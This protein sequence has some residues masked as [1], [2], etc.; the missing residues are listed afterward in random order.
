MQ[1]TP[2]RMFAQSF[3]DF[4]VILVGWGLIGLLILVTVA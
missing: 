2:G 1:F 4:F 3:I